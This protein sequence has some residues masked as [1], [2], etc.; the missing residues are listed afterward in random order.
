[1]K[2]LQ[3]ACAVTLKAV[4]H[5]H[6]PTALDK[7]NKVN[8]L[9]DNN[10]I[11]LVFKR[12]E[13]PNVYIRMLK[14]LM[15]DADIAADDDAHAE[16]SGELKELRQLLKKRVKSFENHVKS[17]RVGPTED[18]SDSDSSDSDSDSSDST[19]HSK[20]STMKEDIAN[21]VEEC[22]RS[23]SESNLMGLFCHAAARRIRSVL[24]RFFVVR[25]SKF[26]S[27]QEI[28]SCR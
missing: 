10:R 8:E 19:C 1:M 28:N 24:S 6:W 25:F 11:L 13:I 16:H 12:V 7:F 18:G 20:D 9:F 21:M 4:R 15:D 3:S 17:C 23:T 27:S 26:L 2:Q 14:D 5:S 22:S